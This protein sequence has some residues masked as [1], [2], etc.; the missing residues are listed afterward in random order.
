M[1]V[2]RLPTLMSNVVPKPRAVF[3]SGVLQSRSPY[4]FGYRLFHGS[5]DGPITLCRNSP[6]YPVSAPG[7]PR[8]SR[9]TDRVQL[10][11][12]VNNFI[13]LPW[14]KIAS[15]GIVAL[16]ASQLKDFMGVRSS[17]HV[18]LHMLCVCIQK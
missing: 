14:Q 3:V 12:V 18:E 10:S 11:H 16:L 8:S 5:S 2:L 7:E 13:N 15:W 9:K 6:A 17:S 1:V 4:P